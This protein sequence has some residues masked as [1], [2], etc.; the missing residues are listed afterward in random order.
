MPASNKVAMQLLVSP[1]VRDT[2]RAVAIVRRESV[3]E[4]LRL[5]AEPALDEQAE[6][7]VSLADVHRDYVLPALEHLGQ[8]LNTDPKLAQV[9]RTAIEPRLDELAAKHGPRVETL[10][11]AFRHMRVDRASALEAMFKY[12]VRYADLFGATG[13]PLDEFPAPCRQVG[14]AP[15]GALNQ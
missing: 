2:A 3:A 1:D 8:L 10:Y 7:D 6:T 9:Y 12:K 4:I 14:E 13:A 5:L 15:E 11:A